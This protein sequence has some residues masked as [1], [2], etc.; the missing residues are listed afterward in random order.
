VTPENFL[1]HMLNPG[2][3]QLRHL[4]GPQV[5]NA[6]ER[7]LL[8]IALQENGP[9]LSARYQ[10]HPAEVAAPAKGW[11]QFELSGV[12]GVMNHGASAALAAKLAERCHVA[13]NA[14]AVYRAIEGHDILAA[15][16]A[17]LLVLTEREPV[18][19]NGAVGWQQYLRLWRPGKP[20]E[21]DWPGN[22]LWA[23]AVITELRP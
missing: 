14:P 21:K 16:I 7:F 8:A 4:G 5:T 3:V 15:G 1:R 9:T 13:R 2:L 10:G 19:I 20:R 23:D 17:R 18:P 22:W 11:W 6:V 12:L